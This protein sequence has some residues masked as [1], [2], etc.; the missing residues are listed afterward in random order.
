ERTDR[1][2][3]LMRSRHMLAV[4][5]VAAMSVPAAAAAAQELPPGGTFVDDN[6][7][8]HEP[9]IEAIAAEGITRGCN[10]PLNDRFCPTDSVTRGQMAAFLVRTLSLPT[11]PGDYDPFSDDDGSI[12]EDDIERLAQA[13][14]TRGCNATS[15]CP[16]D[17]VTREQ[18]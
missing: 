16:E 9:D 13:D 1:R 2:G 5:L 18:M 4:A 11:V 14:I 17:P 12:F 10:P 8:I 6:G 7:S 15:F 3:G